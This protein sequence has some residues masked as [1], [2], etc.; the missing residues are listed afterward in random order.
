MNVRGPKS[1]KDLLMVNGKSCSTFRESAENEDY[2]YV[3][4]I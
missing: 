2:Y 1:Y 3:I 4:I